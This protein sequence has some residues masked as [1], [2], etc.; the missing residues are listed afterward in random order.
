MVG[1]GRTWP[2]AVRTEVSLSHR[3]GSTG[4]VSDIARLERFG[5]PD[6]NGLAL[7]ITNEAGLWMPPKQ[8]DTRDRDFRL[9]EGRTL[10]NPLLRGGGDYPAN[11][12]NLRGSFSLNWQ[13]HSLQDGPGGEFR[14]LAVFTERQP[15]GLM[16][17][18]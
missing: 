18:S 16:I 5:K 10:P 7:L 14:Q 2:G 1:Y 17:Q 11:T 9:H 8:D 3:P 4:F 12:R 6:R 13:P 15:S